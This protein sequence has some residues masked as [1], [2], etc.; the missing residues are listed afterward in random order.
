M[1]TL[2]ALIAQTTLLSADPYDAGRTC[3]M[4]TMASTRIGYPD[5]EESSR[6]NFYLVS[7]SRSR[8]NGNT[9]LQSLSGIMGEEPPTADMRQAA[10]L[11][12]ECEKRFPREA[13]PT[14]VRL[15]AEK[16]DRDAMCYAV[17]R[18]ELA[19][20]STGLTVEPR[21]P[22]ISRLKEALNRL[23][24]NAPQLA[25]RRQGVRDAALDALIDRQLWASFELSDP[26]TV[27]RACGL[28]GG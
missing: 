15:P 17:L 1:L 23:T 3:A 19:D 16:M 11:T 9:V 5:V 26:L 20:V 24:D 2:L 7:A 10:A 6:I 13:D 14:A 22:W 25:K 8:A 18:L 12:R 28:T 27:A 4:V 21:D